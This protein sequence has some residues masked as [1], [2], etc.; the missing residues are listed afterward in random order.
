MISMLNLWADNTGKTLTHALRVPN[1]NLES[2]KGS[3]KIIKGDFIVANN[4]L[5]TL[6]YGPEKVIGGCDYDCSENQLTSLEFG[7]KL[8]EGTF[9]CTKNNIRD[10]YEEI[11][12][13]QINA[14]A[15]ITDIG[16]ITF[17]D[18]EEDFNK[19]KLNNRVTRPSMRKLLG[20]K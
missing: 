10:P 4:L 15:Y 7:P 18:I 2:L 19:Y 16:Y 12:K 17:A 5:K 6:Q 9:K 13:H 14:S 8:V 20:L 1:E 11:C 3:P